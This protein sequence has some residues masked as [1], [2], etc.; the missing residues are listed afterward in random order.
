MKNPPYSAQE[1]RCRRIFHNR[2]R[3]ILVPGGDFMPVKKS[4]ER[5]TYSNVAPGAL[6]P[7]E[8]VEGEVEGR[9]Y[10]RTRRLRRQRS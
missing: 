9:S 6:S 10:H 8:L 4:T 3:I 2:G 5:I 7:R 1:E